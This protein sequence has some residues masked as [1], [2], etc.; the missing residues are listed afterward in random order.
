MSG[1][2]TDIRPSAIAGT[3]YTNNADA[4]RQELNVYVSEAE[5]PKI[6]NDAIVGL[7]APHAGFRYSGRTA[8]YAY[9]AIRDADYD[10]VA[11]FS[12]F[13]A[14]TP[15]KLLTTSHMAYQ[16]PL[17]NIP[18]AVDLLTDFSKEMEE[19]GLPVQTLPFDKEHSLEI[20][21]P[22][23]QTVLGSSFDLFPLMV[24]T[25]TMKEIE[26]IAQ[27]A[28]DIFSKKRILLVASTDLSH[29]YNQKAARKLDEEMLNRMAAFSPERVLAA[30]RTG[31]AFACGAGAV[32]V[33]LQIAKLMGAGKV[34][35][36]HYSTS[37]D[38]TGDASAV[39]GYGA[40]LILR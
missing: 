16:T 37:F 38:A 40:A 26:M 20:Q 34:K 39:V 7:I 17:G 25:Q 8:G 28:V 11:V 21:L 32:A 33:V 2:V 27:T 1:S 3:W 31:K 6:S 23:L 14:Y 19:K 22:F 24:R 12:P 35:L 29:F 13:H 30:E 9:R 5:I 15:Q 36:L 18:V 4:L 10:T